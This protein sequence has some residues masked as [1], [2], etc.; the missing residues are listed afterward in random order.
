M[1]ASLPLPP[2]VSF[3]LSLPTLLYD[4]SMTPYPLI[5]TLSVTLDLASLLS[6]TLTFLPANANV[7]HPTKTIITLVYP[8][9]QSI[10]PTAKFV[11]AAVDH[12]PV[13]MVILIKHDSITFEKLPKHSSRDSSDRSSL[14]L[15]AFLLPLSTL[16]NL[17]LAQRKPSYLSFFRP[18]VY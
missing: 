5:Y 16:T 14:I 7:D 1:Q 2:L 17:N 12:P 4:V 15:P 18:L 3:P 11:R 8:I 10:K 6:Q 13:S 9:L